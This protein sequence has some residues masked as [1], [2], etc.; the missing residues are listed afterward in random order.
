VRGDAPEARRSRLQ[1]ALDTIQL[2]RRSSLKKFVGDPTPFE[3]CRPQLEKYLEAEY[4]EPRS[5]LALP[6]AL[7]AVCLCAMAIWWA[8]S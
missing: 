1:Y 5:S 7:L 6:A 4:N 3:L 8:V 2:E